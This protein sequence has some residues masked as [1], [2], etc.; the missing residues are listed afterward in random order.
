MTVQDILVF[1]CKK[2]RKKVEGKNENCQDAL[3]KDWEQKQMA[4]QRLSANKSQNVKKSQIFFYIES[5]ISVS[6]PESDLVANFAHLSFA[7]KA[8]KFKIGFDVV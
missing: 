4:T 1:A 6:V 5:E 7:L 8:L 2:W 3:F